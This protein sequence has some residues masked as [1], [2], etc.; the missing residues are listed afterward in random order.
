MGLTGR[1]TKAVKRKEKKG[2]RK[3]A[4]RLTS[5]RTQSSTSLP[6]YLQ[7]NKKAFLCQ[8]TL[9]H[10]SLPTSTRRTR[11]RTADELQPRTKSPRRAAHNRT[12]GGRVRKELPPSLPPLLH[13]PPSSN[14]LP[15]SLPPPSLAPLLRRDTLRRSSC[16]PSKSLL[17]LSNSAQ[18]PSGLALPSE[19]S[20]K[21][22]SVF[23]ELRLGLLLFAQ[24]C[25]PACRKTGLWGQ[26]HNRKCD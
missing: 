16:W 21:M 15:P 6:P 9:L 8:G 23:N 25:K 4:D 20:R 24:G 7:K 5:G 12:P 18:D 11:G 17:E 22:R 14:S 3:G 10:Q 13:F 2:A 26:K 19:R 1:V